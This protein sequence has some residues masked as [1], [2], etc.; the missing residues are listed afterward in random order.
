MVITPDTAERMH[1]RIS[2]EV[3]DA[4]MDATDGKNLSRAQFEAEYRK[5][6]NEAF[7]IFRAAMD[8]DVRECFDRAYAEVQADMVDE[9]GD[10][11]WDDDRGADEYRDH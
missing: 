4:V 1:T 2:F 10:F 6:F 5:A 11:V 8:P 7:A 9:D 3:L